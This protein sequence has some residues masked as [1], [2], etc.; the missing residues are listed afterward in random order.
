MS[1]VFPTNHS[2]SLRERKKERERGERDSFMYF[3]LSSA[4]GIPFGI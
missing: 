3:L 2:H 4:L 1:C